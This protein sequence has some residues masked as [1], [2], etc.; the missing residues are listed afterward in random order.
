MI[1]VVYIVASNY[2]F[3]EIQ[4]VF[5]ERLVKYNL[6]ILIFLLIKFIEL[7][8]NLIFVF[9]LSFILLSILIMYMVLRII[10]NQPVHPKEIQHEPYNLHILRNCRLSN[11]KPLYQ[12]LLVFKFC[13]HDT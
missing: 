5:Q 13:S 8:V 7:K 3:L 12:N 10:L 2:S 4:I 11:A 1:L 6:S 9:K